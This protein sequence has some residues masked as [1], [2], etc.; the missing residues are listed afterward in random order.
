MPI[1]DGESEVLLE[2]L[3]EDDH[4]LVVPAIGEGVLAFRAFEANLI[5]AAE[6]RRIHRFLP[7]GIDGSN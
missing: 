2:G 5:H 6:E 4:V 7:V 1:S 3:A